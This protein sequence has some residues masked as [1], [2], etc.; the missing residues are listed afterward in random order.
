MKM[1]SGEKYQH[2]LHAQSIPYKMEM[3]LGPLLWG[4]LRVLG[5]HP[6]TWAVALVSPAAAASRVP[7]TSPAV[8]RGCVTLC[9]PPSPFSRER[10]LGG[11]LVHCV[12]MD[13]AKPTPLN[14]AYRR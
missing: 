6:G 7:G 1:L 9:S 10:G 14:L 11:W 3:A 8:S 4:C 5:T 2:T 13:G 12:E